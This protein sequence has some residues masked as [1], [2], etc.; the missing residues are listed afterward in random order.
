MR[1]SGQN[2]RWAPVDAGSPVELATCANATA[3]GPSGIR[4]PAET[5][6]KFC[7]RTNGN[8]YSLVTLTGTEVEGDF[9]NYA[10]FDITTWD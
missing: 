6:L 4:T 8:R 1:M 5:G 2:A 7:V 3:Y 10:S 9:I